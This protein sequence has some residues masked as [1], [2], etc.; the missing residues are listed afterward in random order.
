[1]EGHLR[2]THE[3]GEK[4]SSAGVEAAR[5]LPRRLH[6]WPAD[7]HPTPPCAGTTGCPVSACLRDP[8][9]SDLYDTR[10]R[11]LWI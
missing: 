1:M 11:G 4:G 9:P 7:L 2:E 6:A 3:K 5:T 8:V 10:Q